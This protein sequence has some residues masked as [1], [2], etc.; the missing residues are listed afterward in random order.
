MCDKVLRGMHQLACPL[1]VVHSTKDNMTDPDGSKLLVD[2]AKVGAVV[3]HACVAVALGWQLLTCQA[4]EV[5]RCLQLGSAF[6]VMFD[7]VIEHVV[8]SIT[9]SMRD[10]RQ[11]QNSRQFPD[12]LT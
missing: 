2:A 7:R 1:F 4:Q 9:F 5:T 12:L 3:C 6:V 8:Y 10:S 11:Q